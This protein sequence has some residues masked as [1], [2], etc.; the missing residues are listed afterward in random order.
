MRGFAGFSLS[1]VALSFVL[2]AGANAASSKS[3]DYNALLAQPDRTD[4]DKQTD[5]RRH[6]AE[7][8]A[9]TACKPGMKALDM[10]ADA[11]YSTELMA[12]CAGPKGKVYAQNSP[13]LPQRPMDAFKARMDKPAMKNVVSD[14]QPFETPIPAGVR[15]LDLITFFFAYHDVANTSTDRAK[16]NK[17]LFNALKKGGTLVITDYAAAPGA[18]ATTSKEYHRLDEA[19]EKKEIE[20]AGFKFAGEGNFL[21]APSDTHDFPTGGAK[22]PLDIYV[23]KFKKP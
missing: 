5:A 9:F 16:M 1:L 21:R 20:A 4:A 3:P 7:L 13:T 12:R 23:L 10:A 19:I 8:L 14:V 18:P 11:G 2:T 15:N 17:A 6:A 22:Q